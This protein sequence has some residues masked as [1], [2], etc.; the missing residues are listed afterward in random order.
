[1]KTPRVPAPALRFEI[2]KGV[3]AHWYFHLKSANGKI[4]A[5]SEGYKR[6]GAALK[7]VNKIKQS[8][9]LASVTEVK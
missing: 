1:M 4:I 6:R 8:A 2:F 3:F 9:F 5:Q 7:A